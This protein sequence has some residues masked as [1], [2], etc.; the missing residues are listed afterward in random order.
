MAPCPHL[1]ERTGRT[2]GR[3]LPHGVRRCPEHQAIVDAAGNKTRN[4]RAKRGGRTTAYWKR[5]RLQALER[6]HNRCT[7]G[8]P[9]CTGTATHVH[10]RPELQGNHLAAGLADCRSAC[11]HCHGVIDAPRAQG[12]PHDPE[13]DERDTGGFDV[14][15]G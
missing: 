8:L 1:D 2:C 10:I 4:E 3:P 9:G 7:F 13:A 15:L 5:L 12:R 6:D 11:P 14:W